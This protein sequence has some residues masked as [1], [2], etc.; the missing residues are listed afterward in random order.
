MHARIYV[1]LG[2]QR[3]LRPAPQVSS[4][5]VA[6]RCNA[7]GTARAYRQISLYVSSGRWPNGFGGSAGSP[8]SLHAVALPW[9]PVL[10]Q[11]PGGHLL[12]AGARTIVR[13]QTVYALV[14]AKQRNETQQNLN[15]QT[16]AKA[17]ATGLIGF[18]VNSA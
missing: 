11:I 1:R 6:F 2:Q 15:R 7:F 12:A 18:S 9:Q 16:S 8:V 14:K 3:S 17:T 13:M 5:A 4:A 10:M